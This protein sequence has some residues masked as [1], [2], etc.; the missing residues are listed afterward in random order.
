MTSDGTVQQGIRRW[1]EGGG[2]GTGSALRTLAW[3][4]EWA[5]GRAVARRN[6]DFNRT[7]GERITGLAVVSVGNLVV[8]GTGK[9]PLAAWTARLLA[10]SGARVA[11]LTGGYSR[12]EILLHQ[13]WNPRVPVVSERSRVDGARLARERG[14]DVAVLDD[15]FQ[16][17]ALARD[18]DLVL[19]AAEDRF[20]GH[21]LPRGPY[22]EPIGSLARA[23]AVVVT[24]RTARA[25]QAADLEAEVAR[26][27]PL[28]ELGRVAFVT[29]GWQDLSGR[30]A[31][32]PEGPVLAATA[33]ARPECFAVQAASEAGGGVEL[34]AFPDHHEFDARDAGVM[35]SRAGERTVVVTEKDAVKL[36]PFESILEPVRVL[37]QTLRWEAGESA[38]ANLITAGRAA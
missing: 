35:R 7:G 22:R 2:K 34:M 9:T 21:L 23:H 24:R 16:H 8:G 10:A 36:Q 15:G 5:Y 25:D 38:V 1:W 12:D 14:A 20:P 4:L 28:V 29:G 26:R 30:A 19:L 6:R 11:L 33:V 17:R 13:R 37:A 27:F 3:P 32:L 18:L 31:P